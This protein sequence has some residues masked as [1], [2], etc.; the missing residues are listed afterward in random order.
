MRRFL[1]LFLVMCL[2]AA[3][4]TESSTTASVAQQATSTPIPTAPAVA[5]PTYTVQRG[6]V[7]EEL[8]FTGRWLPRDQVALSFEVSGVTRQVNVRRGDAVTAGQ[9]LADLQIDDLEN[10]LESA[11]LELQT[12]LA[13]ADTSAQ[14][15]VQSVEDAEISYA[16]SNLSLQST[17][18]GVPW[19]SVAT[20]QTNLESAEIAL[21]DAERAYR[22]AVSHPEQAAANVDNA[23]KQLQNAQIS[24]Q[25]AQYNYFQAAQNY[26][27]YQFQIDQAENELIRSELALER[28]REDQAQGSQDPSV[29]SIQLQIQQIQ[30]QIIQSS[31]FAPIDGEVLEITI[32]P[33][34]SV[35]AYSAVITIGRSEPKEAVASIPIGDAQRLSIGLVGICQVLNM[36][37]TAVQCAV[38]QIPLSASDADQTTRVAASLDNVPA[39]QLIEI[40][41]PVDVRE[42]VLWLPPAAIRTFQ[43]RTFVVIQTVDG[44]RSVDVMLGLETDERVE[45]I[46]GVNEGDIVE[47]P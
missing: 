10:Q 5:R 17:I 3:C 45:I 27:N 40:T 25:N 46:S 11:Q 44:P 7:E 38:R 37:E 39:G 47:G 33:G 35:Q 6:N 28:A 9:L 19:T 21:D 12:A 16:N 13:N 31:L 18:A 4:A 29:L 32:Q 1:L 20:A 15:S 24:L 34:D 2:S 42:D 23:Y 22:D 30:D 8:V 26:Q 43:N 36:P 41:M 14:G